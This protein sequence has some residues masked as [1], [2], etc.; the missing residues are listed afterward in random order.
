ML[1]PVKRPRPVWVDYTFNADGTRSGLR[2][3]TVD[4]RESSSPH[5][6]CSKPPSGSLSDSD[7]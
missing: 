1:K 3:V 6:P 7:Q 4:L 2:L 5:P